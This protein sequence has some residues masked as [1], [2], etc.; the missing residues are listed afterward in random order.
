MA[1][2]L[3]LPRWLYNLMAEDERL[4]Q[5]WSSKLRCHSQARLLLPIQARILEVGSRQAEKAW[6]A[7]LL[8][9]VGVGCGKTLAFF[10]LPVVFGFNRSLL[11]VPPDM[12][13]TGDV[14]KAW[15]E[16]SQ[17][18]ALPPLHVI[19]GGVV[20]RRVKPGTLFVTSYSMLSQ[21]KAT[22]FLTRL[23]PDAILCDEVHNLRNATAARTDRFTR[24]MEGNPSTRFI[25][26]SGTL[27]GT[28]LKDFAHLALFALRQETFLPEGEQDFKAWCGVLDADAK[29]KDT[30]WITFDPIV[31]WAARHLDYDQPAGF[32]NQ[33]QVR[34]AFNARMSTVPGV[35]CTTSPSC[36]AVLELE[37]WGNVEMARPGQTAMTIPEALTRLNDTWTLPNGEVL[38]SALERYRAANQLSLGF[39]YVWDWPDGADDDWLEAR[40]AWNRQVRLYLKSYRREGCD[41]P[42]LVE[43]M[44]R[45]GDTK[46]DVL[47]EALAAWDE[48][49][50]KPAP[51]TKAIWLDY[52]PIIAIVEWSQR[53]EGIVWFRSKA[54][55]KALQD[56]GLKA[57]WDGLPHPKHDRRVALSIQTHGT[58]KNF[59]AWDNNLVCEIPSSATLWEQM[60]GRTHRQ[61][62]T[63]EVV[64]ATVMQHT[65]FLVQAWRK[66]LGRAEF[67]AGVTSQMQRLCF[68]DKSGLQSALSYD[69]DL[70]DI[71]GEL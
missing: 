70:D 50:G 52:S 22:D 68:A 16:W 41:S 31:K 30:D 64:Q 60:L 12:L 61:G 10:L 71:G 46:S 63:S 21:A 32:G 49:R 17:E 27:V 57:M 18:Y 58:G 11:L 43:Q 29:A 39:Y 67:V 56:F 62:Q 7:G 4:V 2:I 38:E 54:V 3:A 25:G 45:R 6:P 13:N 48:Q 40:S 47:I 23:A 14:A 20:P 59:Q 55:G 51:P 5:K 24:Y 8:G 19:Q 1:R 66:A 69:P 28:S 53:N 33:E 9:S 15:N 42:Y 44:V 34:A 65:A 26:M 37:G 36:E 35:L